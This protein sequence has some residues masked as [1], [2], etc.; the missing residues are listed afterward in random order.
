MGG[1][2]KINKVIDTEIIPN[3]Y[4]LTWS[5]DSAFA[6]QANVRDTK[7]IVYNPGQWGGSIKA[8]EEWIVSTYGKLPTIE[9]RWS[10]DIVV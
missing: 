1:L 9:Y 5:A 6:L 10:K 2:D 7:V 4:D 8:L 3:R